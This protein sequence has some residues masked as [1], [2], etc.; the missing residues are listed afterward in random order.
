MLRKKAFLIICLNISCAS[1]PPAPEVVQYGIYN[2]VQPS[3][4][5]GVNTKTGAKSYRQFED[6]RIKGAQCLVRQDFKAMQ[7]WISELKKIAEKRCK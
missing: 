4:L 2:N 6:P 1:L 7:D 5:Y 3:G